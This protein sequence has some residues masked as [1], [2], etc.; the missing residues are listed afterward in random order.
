MADISVTA[1]SVVPGSGATFLRATAGGS[2]TAG[3]PVYLDSSDSNKAKAADANASSATAAAVGIAIHSCSSGQTVT[4]QTGGSITIGATVAAGVTYFVSATA[5]GIAPAADLAS[6]WYVTRL[7]YAT[8]TTVLQMD[9][10]ATGVA[11]A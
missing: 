5:G 2:I 11:I 9:L 3:Q 4:Y 1:G 8:S 6:G 10:L 7:G